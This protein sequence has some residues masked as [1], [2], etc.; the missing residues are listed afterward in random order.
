MVT[1]DDDDGRALGSGSFVHLDVISA[2]SKLA[3]PN[4]PQEYVAALTRQFPLDE[5]T[6]D[7]EPRPAIALADYGLQSAVKMAVVCAKEGVE[8]LCGLRL[9]VAPEAS[10]HPWAEQPGELL[11]LAGDEEAWLSLVALHN[12]THLSGA[13]HR[14]PRVD[15][16]DLEELCCGELICLTGAPLVGVLAPLI[17]GSADPTNPV[18]AVPL[19]RRLAEL[20]P[21]RFYLEVAYHGHPREKLV[22]RALMALGSKLDLPLVATNAVRYARREDA[23]AAA[24]LDAMRLNRRD[25]R[26]VSGVGG[27]GD[28]QELPIVGLD[29]AMVH[30]QAY[31]RTPREMHRLFAQLPHAL[32]AAV[33]IRDRARFRLPL[34]KDQPA[35]ERYGPALLFGLGPALDIDRHR[36]G[37][38]VSRTLAERF[39]ATG[40][41]KATSEIL[42]RAERE[43]K[44]LCRAGLAELM[45]TAYDLAQFCRQRGMP[46]AAR[47]SATCSLVAWSFGLVE[48]CP[49]D[50]GLDSQLFVHEGWGDLP[51]LDL[52]ISSLH[53][54]AISTFLARYGTDRLSHA[55]PSPTGLPALGTLRL[56]INV[57]L[58]ARQ[59]VRAT[60]AALGLDPIALNGLARQVPLLSS[61]GAVDQVLL[62]SP[63][64]GG[65]LSSTFE[66]G[67]TILRIAGQLE[68]LPHRAGAHPSAYAVSFLGPGALSWLPAQ[69]VS[70]DRPGSS[71][72][73]GPRHL[74]VTAQGQ[75]GAVELSHPSAIAPNQLTGEVPVT[76]DDDASAEHDEVLRVAAGTGGG[77]VLACAFDKADFE[78]LGIPRLDIST[79]AA[80]ATASGD[81]DGREPADDIQQGVWRMLAAGDTRCI[82]Q[83]ET[84]GMQRLLRRVREAAESSPHPPLASLE[85]L[86]QLL[87]L[88]RPGAFDPQREQAYLAARF[89]SQRPVSLHPAVDAVL[90]PTHGALLYADQVVRLILL[91]GFPYDWAHRYRRALATGRR[92]ERTAMERELKEAGKLRRW[93]DDQLNGLL[94]LLQEHAGYLYAHGHALALANHV[95]QQAG[96]KLDQATA[97]SF[98]AEVLNNGGSAHY[99]LGAAVEEARQWACCCCHRA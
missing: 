98:F 31:L 99:G 18:E 9:R 57:S 46:L 30:A 80:M 96:R 84:P 44:D 4:T 8:H 83:V 50:Y 13:D 36:L 11:L 89:G 59:A 12:R 71:R 51:D 90:V 95:L 10:W 92:A 75:V 73:G 91:F 20:F 15:L 97:P 47:G 45:L 28:G 65:G 23:Q 39:A 52:E 82:S 21:D 70:A 56:G 40:R 76:T 5:H 55:E 25:E 54:P 6:P 16:Q 43:V 68:G 78:A 81:R 26:A 58:G 63:E 29:A 22:N 27:D 48:L 64:L 53:E 88:W 33:E 77:P 37:E 67:Q 1:T 24:V 74:A 19:A 62:R 14:G 32:A 42:T 2:Y 34:A 66:P 79:S 41:G 3:S 69:W 85:D 61:P 49:L 7:D 38:L 72:F 93:S 17:A 86:A 60:G 87:A 94:G 35:E